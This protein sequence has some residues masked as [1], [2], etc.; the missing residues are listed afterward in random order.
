[1]H[2]PAEGGELRTRP[3]RFQGDKLVLNFT[4]GAKGSLAV[5]LQD[6]EG[7]PLEGFSLKDCQPLSGDAVAQTVTWKGTSLNR[8]AG[9]PVRLRFVLR[10]ADLFSF[11]FQ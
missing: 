7:R 6:L 3:L 1:M 4:T 11:R 8:L 5:E 10:D 9:T 2:A